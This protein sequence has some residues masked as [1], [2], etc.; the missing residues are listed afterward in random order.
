[1]H[2]D[3]HVCTPF[4]L[5]KILTVPISQIETNFTSDDG[6]TCMYQIRTE[7]EKE[8]AMKKLYHDLAMEDKRRNIE[9]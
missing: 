1:M 9:R 2:Y 5:Y 8:L 3:L 4:S 6:T 7:R